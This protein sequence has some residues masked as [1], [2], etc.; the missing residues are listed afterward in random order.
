LAVQA[1]P[2]FASLARPGALR[3]A[4]A[5]AADHPALV[6][7]GIGLLIALAI[8]ALY[9]ATLAPSLS[10]VSPDGNELA[11]IPYTLGLAHPTG[12]PLYTWLGKAFTYLPVGDIA[13]RV[14]L[15]S[16]VG[17]AGACGLL[18]GI[19]RELRAERLA[20]AFAAL[21]LGMSTT[22]WS[23]ATISE[24]YGPN[25]I[26]VALEL[27][28]LL[29][30]ARLQRD[31]AVRHHGSM[32]STW[33]FS[34][35]ALTFALSLGMHLSGLGLGLGFGVYILLVNWRVVRQP[36]VVLPALSVFALGLLQFL[37]IPVRS[38][39]GE[40]SPDP[41]AP[42]T[43][44]GFLSYTVNAFPQFKWQYPVAVLPDRFM[45][46]GQYVLANFGWT[47]IALGAVGAS[48]LSVLRPRTFIMLALLW[49]VQV[50]F[51]MEYRAQDLDVFFIPA[52]LFLAVA[53]GFGA[54]T[55]VVAAKE[56]GQ[57][58]NLSAGAPYATAAV[59]L[60]APLLFAL[61][62]NYAAND[63]SG[64]TEINDFYR[65]VYAALPEGAVLQ[66]S[67]GVGGFDTAYYQ[68]V[69]GDRPDVTVLAATRSRAGGAATTQGRP[70]YTVNGAGGF[71]RGPGQP[72]VTGRD[73]S[74]PVLISP[75][76]EQLVPIFGRR[77][78]TLYR[79]SQT[80]PKLVT[81]DMPSIVLEAAGPGAT[82]VGAD[83]SSPTVRRGETVHVRLYWRVSGPSSVTLSIGAGDGPT[84]THQVG[85]GLLD[86]YSR[87]VESI[88]GKTIVEE[89]DLVVLSSTPAGRQPLVA[90]IGGG[91]NGTAITTATLTVE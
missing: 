33:L 66:G 84:T 13:H 70:A 1:I 60:A 79:S 28:L 35:W 57:R 72:A 46:Y 14:N 58:L 42:V 12:Y 22:L 63:Q 36:L 48:A 71:G 55:L 37:W 4:L 8:F 69:Y 24:V 45:L 23:Q 54:S 11:T 27:L 87:E 90:R 6:D 16:A 34:A 29:K 80:P 65:N 53:I 82:L 50:V 51:F 83:L 67:P 77:D 86:R 44:D 49:A 52:H 62:D 15:M 78:L 18:Y 47:G 7:G 76:H 74:I 89:F 3:R 2:R 9:N 85:F 31:P 41:I 17:A 68:M 64:H 39:M 19:V 30:W 25:L 38:A 91:A 75:A 73:W 43:I 61:R 32:Q 26:F 5:A 40:A 59:L 88:Q 21:A 81:S 10:Y 56:A 20:A